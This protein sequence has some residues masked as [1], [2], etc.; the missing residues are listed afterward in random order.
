MVILSS[1]T[2]QLNYEDLVLRGDTWSGDRDSHISNVQE[3]IAVI[4]MDA[5]SLGEV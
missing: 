5:R 4:G 3:A 2:R 1:S